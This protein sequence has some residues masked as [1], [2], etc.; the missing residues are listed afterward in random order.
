M[1]RDFSA[2]N[3]SESSFIYRKLID[4]I[5]RP[6]H[7]EVS[8]LIREN[9]TVIDVAC[10]T[11]ALSFLMAERAGRV[12]GIDISQAMIDAANEAKGKRG[13][14]NVDFFQM[15]A[16]NLRR[17]R[18]GEFN[19]STLSMAMHQF[20]QELG[21]GVLKELKRISSEIII[22]DY[23]CPFPNGFGGSAA[24]IIERFAG[25]EHHRNFRAF[26]DKGGLGPMLES[27]GWTRVHESLII[28]GIF[29]MVKCR[30]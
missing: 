28:A 13:L 21:L 24:R 16:A 26:I 9:Q 3:P 20:P 17:F 25:R 7:L 11:G 19:V 1:I 4:P 10:G 18:D 12:V 15:D 23:A 14:G 8:S 27:A 2:M 6:L 5:L 29:S 22:A 30:K